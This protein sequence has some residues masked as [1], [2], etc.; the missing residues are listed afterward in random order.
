MNFYELLGISNDATDKE[1]KKAYVL[2]LRQ[3]PPEQYPE[4]FDQLRRAYE[5]LSNIDSRREYDTMSVHGEEINR[6]ME[7]GTNNLDE[8]QFEEAG[9][10][11]KK[12]LLIDSNLH[13]ARNMY[14]LSLTYNDQH[15]KSLIQFNKLI[16]SEPKNSTYHYNRALVLENLKRYGEAEQSYRIANQLAPHNFQIVL[17]WADL[18]H[19]QNQIDKARALLDGAVGLCTEDDFQTAFMYLFK[20]L[21]LEIIEKKESA[22][23][24]IFQRIEALLLKR[25]EEQQ[26]VA[27]EYAGFAFELYEYKL[28]K[29]AEKLT[30]RAI[31]LNPEHEKIRE[32]HEEV[33]TKRPVY[34]EQEQLKD[35]SSIN[36]YIKQMY[37]LYLFGD[38]VDDEQ[39]E[40]YNE[41]V[42]DNLFMSAKYD[43]ESIISSVKRIMLHYP[44]LFELKKEL[45]QK[46]LELS[47]ERM[48]L[49]QQYEKLQVDVGVI[50][51]L[52]RM[53]A[54]QLSDNLSQEEYDRYFN[55]IMNDFSHYRTDTIYQSI[56]RV[57]SQYK[58]CFDVN[59]EL[60]NEISKRSSP[61]YNAGSSGSR[62][63]SQMQSQSS[64][65]FVATVAYGT[66]LI[67]ELD[68]LRTWRD[69]TLRHSYVGR[70]FIKIYYK[71]GPKWAEWVGK[72]KV[73]MHLVRRFLCWWVNQL[74][75]K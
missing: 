64:S 31:Q 66:P 21:K 70:K 34:A 45:L 48:K 2:K 20:R 59:P 71:H 53:V 9:K 18:Y 63:S 33:A 72:S 29:W 36:E 47:K 37:L 4:D 56:Q 39:F 68:T 73:R 55:D 58:A 13:F 16:E 62:P 10:Q 17:D 30:E 51:P 28:Y 19:N 38:E 12:V 42:F 50:D 61:A 14:A 3:Y 75:T 6:L 57:R 25:P 49:D 74:N 46:I 32:L 8:K 7:A 15:D 54:L 27:G 11:F 67:E 52:K 69:S 43:Y 60:F 22:I 41:R 23:A 65:C 24:S 1:L 40:T 35:D 26:Y 44:N 5:T